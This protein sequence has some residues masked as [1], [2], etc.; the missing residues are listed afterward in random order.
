MQE[1]VIFKQFIHYSATFK[2]NFV[3]YC[4]ENLWVWFVKAHI[5]AIK[6]TLESCIVQSAKSP[7]CH[8]LPLQEGLGQIF[9]SPV[10]TVHMRLRTMH[11]QEKL[12]NIKH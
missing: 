8:I 1:T 4:N 10:V 11:M 5:V 2:I 7:K 9:N 12:I 6:G 3:M